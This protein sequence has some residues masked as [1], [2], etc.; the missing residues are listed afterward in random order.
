MNVYV[1]LSCSHKPTSC[2]SH[3]TGKYRVPF[4]VVFFRSILILSLHLC[5]NNLS[6]I[7]FQSFQNKFCMH[8]SLLP[9][10]L[11]ASCSSFPLFD[12]CRRIHSV[13]LDIHVSA[14]W[15]CFLSLKSAFAHQH[16][17]LKQ[18]QFFFARHFHP[19]KITSTFTCVCFSLS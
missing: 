16:T 1:L 7:S 12:H 6:V 13:T 8:I 10:M 15:C 4:N 2:P 3:Q 9:C 5:I 19:Y 11:H 14:S 18:H 17:V